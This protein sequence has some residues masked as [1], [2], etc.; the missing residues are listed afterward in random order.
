VLRWALENGAFDYLL[1]II[2]L[3]GKNICNRDDITLGEK[4]KLLIH[5]YSTPCD[6]KILCTTQ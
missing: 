3:N 4:L 6:M 1:K 5:K 2:T